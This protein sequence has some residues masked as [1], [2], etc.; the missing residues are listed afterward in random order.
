MLHKPP[1]HP[2]PDAPALG[3]GRDAHAVVLDLM[4]GNPANLAGRRPGPRE[5]CFLSPSARPC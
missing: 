3:P 2:E 4:T 1:R 5:V